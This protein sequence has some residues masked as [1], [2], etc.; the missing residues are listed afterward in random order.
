[1]R[2]NSQDDPDKDIVV[3]E[4]NSDKEEDTYKESDLYVHTLP[5]AYTVYQFIKNHTY[6]W[7]IPNARMYA[8]FTCTYVCTN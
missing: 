2:S 3:D 5:F 6:I 4:Y 1:M 8:H 7:S